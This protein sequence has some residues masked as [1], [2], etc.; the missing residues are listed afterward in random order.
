MENITAVE[1]TMVKGFK[2]IKIGTNVKDNRDHILRAEVRANLLNC[3]L[4]SILFYLR[5]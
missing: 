5:P 1:E 4:V 2:C 3:I